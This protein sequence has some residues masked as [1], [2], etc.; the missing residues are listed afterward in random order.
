LVS[1]EYDDEKYMPQITG[2][3]CR[4]HGKYFGPH[5]DDPPE[6]DYWSGWGK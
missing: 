4:V 2:T 5:N 3:A 1:A 6:E